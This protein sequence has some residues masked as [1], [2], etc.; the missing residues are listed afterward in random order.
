M[1]GS[2][3]LVFL[4]WCLWAAPVRGEGR[5]WRGDGSGSAPDA[6]PPT[7]WDID[8]REHILWQ[9]KVGK[10]QS[11][12]VIVE[13][14]VFLTAEPDALVC[15]DRQGGKLLWNR[16]HGPGTLPPEIK[17]P[18]KK[19]PTAAGCGYATPTPV[20]DGKLVYVVFG[21]GIVACYGLDGNRRWIRHL[22]LPQITEYGRSASPVLVGRK[23]LVSLSGLTALDP[24]TGG[25]LWDAPEAKSSY[26]TPA[27]AKIGDVDVAIT[28]SGACVRVADGKI[29]AAELAA[30]QYTSPLVAGNVV[31]FVDAPTVAFQL[32]ETAG[33]TVRLEKLWE[34][35]D[36]E[37]EFFASPICHEGVLYCA[38]NEG[39]LYALDAKTGEV[40][41]EH[42]PEIGSASGKP[43]TEPAN[44]Y[45]SLALVGRH[46]LLA[47]DAGETLVL[48]PGAQYQ[49]I[50][51]NYLYRGSGA[52][53]APDGDCLLLRGDR[54]LYCIGGP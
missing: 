53:P 31:Y 36:L 10:G 39:M 34:N 13:G 54:D 52:S 17:L 2:V 3:R 45:P 44:I 4:A 21:T 19:Q 20:T 38:S 12:P 18:E 47:N 40:L 30:T 25:T 7:R 27:V 15:V 23:L 33:E 6:R 28:P 46:L 14:R 9:T 42:E 37:G 51:H 49:P 48:V 41:I 43:G 22:D 26:G 50:A 29:L 1:N 11:T 16:T 8:S 32:P 24:Q 35:D 5:G